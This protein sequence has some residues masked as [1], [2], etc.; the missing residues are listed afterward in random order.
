MSRVFSISGL[1]MAAVASGPEPLSPLLHDGGYANDPGTA[2]LFKLNEGDGAVIHDESSFGNLGLAH[3]TE[4]TAGKYGKGLLLDG[5]DDHIQVPASPSLAISSTL[6]LEAWIFPLG[7]LDGVGTIIVK[8]DSYL[9]EALEGADPKFRAGIWRNG[10]SQKVT[11]S[12]RL[13][14]GAWQHIA[15][16]YDGAKMRLY[17]NGQLDAERALT[18]AVDANL[19]DVLIGA[20]PFGTPSRA[21]TLVLDEVRISNV[22]R[23]AAELDPNREGA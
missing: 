13:T 1:G 20:H 21:A 16:V 14:R 23:A 19:S 6:T 10:A 11:S 9:L 22:A 17:F 8:P 7:E 5:I 15:F 12:S 18:G 2:L 4:W 3:G